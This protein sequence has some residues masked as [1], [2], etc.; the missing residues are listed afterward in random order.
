LDTGDGYFVAM[1]AMMAADLMKQ[2]DWKLMKTFRKTN[3]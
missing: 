1:A 3:Q 2:R